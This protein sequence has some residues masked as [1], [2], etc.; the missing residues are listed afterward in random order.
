M[1]ALSKLVGKAILKDTKRGAT[2][3]A[4]KKEFIDKGKTEAQASNLAHREMAKEAGKK[5]AIEKVDV[6]QDRDTSKFVPAGA[7]GGN[8]TLALQSRD[9]ASGDFVSMKRESDEGSTVRSVAE[10]QKLREAGEKM[11]TAGVKEEVKK[12]AKQAAAVAVV[13]G[14]AGKE[15]GESIKERREAKEE[16]ED[17]KEMNK[18]GMIANKGIGASM[19]P[20]NVFGKKK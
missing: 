16:K 8:K 9:T 3:E 12:T 6:K 10:R 2:K 13:G 11:F 7:K 18:G 14:A 17:K 19:K 15:I 20:H 1:G 4:L 5:S